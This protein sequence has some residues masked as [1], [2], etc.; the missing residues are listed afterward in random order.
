[1]ESESKFLFSPEYSKFIRFEFLSGMTSGS[2][3]GSA[4]T[5]LTDCSCFFSSDLIGISCEFFNC[6]EFC[7]FVICSSGILA[8]PF[9]GATG[10][11]VCS[12][13]GRTGE[14]FLSSTVTIS[15]CF[16]GISFFSTISSFFSFSIWFS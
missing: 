8:F 5:S 14:A 6:C 1:M 2:F 4:S 15:F 10:F 9:N 3:T 16:S 13:F 11:F 12:F 7:S